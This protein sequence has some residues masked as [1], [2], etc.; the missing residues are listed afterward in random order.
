MC[1]IG[2]NSKDNPVGP[3][4]GEIEVGDFSEII[5]NNVSPDGGTIT[6]TKNGDS[7]NG[8]MLSVPKGSYSS[9]RNLKIEIAPVKKHTFGEQFVPLTPLIRVSNGGGY[10]DSIMTLEI[11]ITLPEGYFP[12]AFYY[13]N[14]TGEL[15]GIPTGAITDDRIYIGTRHFDGKS[16]SDGKTSIIQA[17]Q[18]YADLIVAA[19]KLGDLNKLLTTGYLPGVDDWEFTNRGSYIAPAG[20]CAGQTITSMWYYSVKKLKENKHSL[21]AYYDEIGYGVPDTM[22]KDNPMGY[23][24]ASVVQKQYEINDVNLIVDKWFKKFDNIGKKRF[25]KDSLHYLSLMYAFN[26]IKKPQLVVIFS[27][28]GG[29]HALVAYKGGNGIIN[30]ADPNY[31]GISTREIEFINGN[32][33]PY[34]SGDNA[35]DLGKPFEDINYAAKSALVD[36]KDIET[37]WQDFEQHK[38]G[39]GYFP[40]VQL[41]YRNE[42]NEFVPAPDPL[43][44]TG[45]SVILRCVCTTCSIT[46]TNKTIL[47]EL[48]DEKGKILAYSDANGLLKVIPD[49]LIPRYGLTIFGYPQNP[50]NKKY[51]DFKWLTLTNQKFEIVAVDKDSIPIK[52]AGDINKEYN[53]KINGYGKLPLSPKFVW[54]FGDNSS[55]ITKYGKDTTA[56]HTYIK[57]GTYNIKVKIYNNDNSTLIS[58]ISAKAKL[59]NNPIITSITP[60]K[61][62]D[63]Q[64][65]VINGSSFGNH[66]RDGDEVCLF[67][68]GN[69]YRAIYSTQWSDTQIKTIINTATNKTGKMSLKVRLYDSDK[70]SYRWSEPV[71]FE[72]VNC[73]ITS[74]DPT[75]LIT[76]SIATL[77]GTGFGVYTEEDGIF[78]YDKKVQEIQSWTDSKIVFKVP[79]LLLNGTIDVDL[80]KGMTDQNDRYSG[81][82][83]RYE[84]DNIYWKP[85]PSFILEYLPIS[86]KDFNSYF[87][88]D[89]DVTTTYYD[90]N[91]KPTSTSDHTQATQINLND[92]NNANISVTDR[93]FRLW[94]NYSGGNGSF[95]C[96]GTIS[97]DGK[98]IEQATIIRKDASDRLVL[99]CSFENLP[100]YSADQWLP[101]MMD[102]KFDYIWIYSATSNS[103][104]FITDFYSAVYTSEG[105]LQYDSKIKGSRKIFL[106]L[107]AGKKQ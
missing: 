87:S 4:S 107:R 28:Q 93:T 67:L 80:T 81:H 52:K 104:S 12:M 5:N 76:D 6:Y 16:L 73:N 97:S 63:G 25:T 7:L 82:I 49:N 105:K 13:D 21:Y 36:F 74:I 106:Q 101:E 40:N 27:S 31:P 71:D 100:L 17:T 10:S 61:G 18:T 78:L 22:W 83:Y 15:E 65:V 60:T 95:E 46:Y 102:T 99:R 42:N 66:Q 20:H 55:L 38:I 26:T 96:I 19:V 89:F 30:I 62:P 85:T 92:N 2:C 39:D 47:L 69:T 37:A 94:G 68:E 84:P 34:M 48:V 9:N 51:I 77:T 53:F 90:A 70:M 64:V 3:T 54:D 43:V 45:D 32:F 33:I 75:I 58:E 79:R 14:E 91:G 57:E 50:Q 41:E 11:P 44:F 103:Y 8:L 88:Y 35:D 72:V 23:R 56:S 24:F 98:K 59:G 86:V 29:G 1:L